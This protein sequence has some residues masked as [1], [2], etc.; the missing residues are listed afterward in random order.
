MGRAYLQS[1]PLWTVDP[2]LVEAIHAA[3]PQMRRNIAIAAAVRAAKTAAWP[4]R[5]REAIELAASGDYSPTART[6]LAKAADESAG[7]VRTAYKAAYAA[8]AADATEA[9]LGATAAVVNGRFDPFL[10]VVRRRLAGP[11]ISPAN[12]PKRQIGKSRVGDGG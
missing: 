12:R 2:D 1:N 10:G 3:W 9:A 11:P 5:T 7:N 8:V 6:W 4:S